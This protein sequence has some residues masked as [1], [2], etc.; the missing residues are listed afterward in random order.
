MRTFERNSGL[1]EGTGVLDSFC[2]FL[3]LQALLQPRGLN[4][5]QQTPQKSLCLRDVYSI[6]IDNLSSIQ[7]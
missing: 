2:L 7:Q 5:I 3:C 4:Q 6:L 1:V